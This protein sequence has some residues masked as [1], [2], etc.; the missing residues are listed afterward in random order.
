MESATTPERR[1][2][3]AAPPPQRPAPR[4]TVAV[5]PVGKLRTALEAALAGAIALAY[6]LI[7][8][9][10]WDTRFDVPIEDGYD[11]RGSAATIKGVLENGWWLHNP[12]LGAP[13]GQ[14]VHDFPASG[15]SLLTR[16]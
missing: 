12:Y 5:F 15:E 1:A 14:N 4:D 9:Q 8:Y 2:P 7:S 11:G 10:I 16:R 6:A 3:A 13:F